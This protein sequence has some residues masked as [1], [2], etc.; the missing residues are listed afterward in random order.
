M[1]QSDP[2]YTVL[3]LTA[4]LSA[5]NLYL[6]QIAQKTSQ[7]KESPPLAP[8]TIAPLRFHRGLPVVQIGSC[9][10]LASH[11][12]SA[13]ATQT[14]PPVPAPPFPPSS[15]IGM[16]GG[17]VDG[18]AGPEP[19]VHR[20]LIRVSLVPS[21]RVR[22]HGGT[23]AT[24]SISYFGASIPSP[25][26]HQ[27]VIGPAGAFVHASSLALATPL[28]CSSSGPALNGPQPFMITRSLCPAPA[29]PPFPGDELAAPTLPHGVASDQVSSSARQSAPR[30][31]GKCRYFATKKG[32][33]L[34]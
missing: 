30:K 32:T 28:S 14:S 22:G 12:I 25:P 34:V 9:R 19:Q 11:P 5:V 18:T 29:Q 13:L 17:S 16:E 7:I 6:Q 10:S 2:R 20:K 21:N 24:D 33:F 31:R 3:A 26:M 27:P 4:R 1:T 23:Q 8:P 15:S